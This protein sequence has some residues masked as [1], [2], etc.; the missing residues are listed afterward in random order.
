MANL[1]S[2]SPLRAVP[3]HRTLTASRTAIVVDASCDL[4]PA[5]YDQPGVVVLPTTVRIGAHEYIDNHSQQAT[6][7]FLAEGLGI[8]SANAETHPYSIDEIRALFLERLVLD[9]DSVYC[10]TVSAKRS[11]IHD[12]ASRASLSILNDSREIRRTAGIARPL[13]LRVI[14]TKNLFAGQGIA[15]LD[16]AD[17]IERGTPPHQITQRLFK[18]VESTYGYFV[19]DDLY[20]LR[21]RA[22][23][24][25]DKSVGLFGTMI[26]K[27]LDIRPVVRASMGI[28]EPVA[29]SRGRDETV[30][31]LFHFVG[32]RV[33][34][35]LMTPH[36]NLSY[37][38]DLDE[39]H[40][41]PGYEEL[42]VL[43]ASKG[44]TLHES[45]MGIT[46]CVNVGPRG[47]AIGF[48]GPP[49]EVVGF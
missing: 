24:R 43:C 30:R 22:R 40:A 46:G 45:I 37:G 23:K 35:G 48:A 12:N 2:V 5:F 33:L 28:T 38:G 27:A 36:V 21:N 10:L 9:Y 13:L 32:Q 41:F 47:V 31:K 6:A 7:R 42:A 8:A 34:A 49:H 16:L 17:M 39:L 18:L 25:G 14:D 20:Y 44:V 3:F 1:A 11:Q 19:P 15:A 26:G 29:K 4:P